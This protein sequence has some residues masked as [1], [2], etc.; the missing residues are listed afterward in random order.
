[1]HGVG[2]CWLDPGLGS[3]SRRVSGLGGDYDLRL[4]ADPASIRTARHWLTQHLRASTPLP[5][6]RIDEAA[7]A[8]GELAANVIMHTRSDL[9]IGVT[10]RDEEVRVLVHD[11]SHDAVPVLQ[12][13][14]PYRIGGNGIRLVEALSDDWGVD[15]I[16]DD[17]KRV[18]F[19]ISLV[20]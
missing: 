8:L 9:A 18:W 17:G 20:A 6:E 4:E 15:P 2:G 12:P 1:M 14:D 11:Q 10:V 7:L 19:A 16:P 13:V 5:P 3:V